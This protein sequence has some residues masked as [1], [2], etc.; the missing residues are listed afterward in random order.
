MWAMHETEYY[1]SDDAI[2]VDD[3]NVNGLLFSSTVIGRKLHNPLA[4][5]EK[6]LATWRVTSPSDSTRQQEDGVSTVS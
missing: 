1:N 5:E 4:T 2:N 6:I 3:S